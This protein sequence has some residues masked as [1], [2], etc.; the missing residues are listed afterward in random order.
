MIEQ[1][2]AY[3]K[4]FVEAKQY[5]SYITDKYPIKKVAILSCMDTRALWSF[6]LRR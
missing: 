6:C 4:Q 2:L 1:M 5:E 3:N